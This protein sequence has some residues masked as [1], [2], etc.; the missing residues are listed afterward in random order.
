MNMMVDEIPRQDFV[1]GVMAPN[2]KIGVRQTRLGLT[3]DLSELMPDRARFF[4][5]GCA[6]AFEDSADASVT[7]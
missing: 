2:K 3:P 7:T 5:S 6:Q 1:V 4:A